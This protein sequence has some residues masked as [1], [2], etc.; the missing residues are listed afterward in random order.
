MLSPADS[1]MCILGIC[2]LCLNEFIP[3]TISGTTMLFPCEFLKCKNQLIFL[4]RLDAMIVQQK[5]D[6]FRSLTNSKY[7]SALFAIER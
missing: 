5:C 1:N 6:Q 3:I 2:A 4:S 7:L